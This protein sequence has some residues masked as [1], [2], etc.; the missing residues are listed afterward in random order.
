MICFHS[1]S[2]LL[3]NKARTIYGVFR[4]GWDPT[5]SAEA[6]SE[7]EPLSHAFERLP[8]IKQH[9]AHV[10]CWAQS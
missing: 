10:G 4:A 9:A 8:L 6:R 3:H 5:Y 7:V 2:P 1:T